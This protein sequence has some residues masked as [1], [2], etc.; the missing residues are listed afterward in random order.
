MKLGNPL[1]RFDPDGLTS[2]RGFPSDKEKLLRDAVE[3]AKEALNHN[4][5]DDAKDVLNR[6]EKAEFVYVDKDEDWCGYV[7]PND[8]LKHRIKIS[9]TA[10][11]PSG[12][13]YGC[14]LPS[15][16]V[17]E[18]VHL[19]RRGMG[20]GPAYKRQGQCFGCPPEGPGYP[21]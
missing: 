19:R 12:P 1:L 5:C 8:W 20:E 7:G 4:C 16:V 21:Q 13:C 2:Y 10:F 15:I 6:L 17:H 18:G 14:P 3:K 11:D 9:R